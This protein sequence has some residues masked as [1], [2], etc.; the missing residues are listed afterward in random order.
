MSEE[1]FPYHNKKA[2]KKESIAD[3]GQLCSNVRRR[4]FMSHVIE[5]LIDPQKEPYTKYRMLFE[6]LGSEPKLCSSS[7]IAMMAAATFCSVEKKGQK[8]PLKR[9]EMNV[10][11]NVLTECLVSR[12]DATLVIH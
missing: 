5:G 12:N 4:F 9:G 3:K 6:E 8:E 2:K 11:V 10:L 1:R 7:T